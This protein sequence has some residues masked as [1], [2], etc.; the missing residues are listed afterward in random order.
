MNARSPGGARP[1]K[2]AL[3]TDGLYPYF[4]GGK[5]VRLWQLAR[6]LRA[7]AVE[8]EVHTMRWWGQGEDLPE[9]DGVR[10]RA[11]CRAWPMYSRSRRS[12]WQ[13]AMFALGSLRLVRH[14]A[15]L[16]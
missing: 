6:R 1:L 13:A 4:A 5:E 2:V 3:V 8:P 16:I 12:V 7:C 15:D 10:V 9:W 11:L 14:K